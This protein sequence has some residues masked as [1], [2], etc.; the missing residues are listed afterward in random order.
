VDDSGREHSGHGG[1]DHHGERTATDPVMANDNV[2][3]RS[4]LNSGQSGNP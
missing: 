3:L 4:P 1:E 2:H